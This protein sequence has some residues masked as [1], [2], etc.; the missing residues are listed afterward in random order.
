M[1]WTSRTGACNVIDFGLKAANGEFIALSE[2][3]GGNQD[4]TNGG[5]PTE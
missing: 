2:L 3:I 1:D 4:N 5:G